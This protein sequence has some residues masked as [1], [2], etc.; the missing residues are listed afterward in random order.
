MSGAPWYAPWRKAKGE[1]TDA[2]KRAFRQG[3]DA[4]GRSHR[5][6]N[7]TSGTGGPNA[8]T[9]TA[10]PL[11]RARS[12][13]LTRNNPWA[14]K[15]VSTL[16]GALVG[17]GISPIFATGDAAENERIAGLWSE[18]AQ[19]CDSSGRQSWDGACR[20][21]ARGFVE[22]GE[23]LVRRR[24][25]RPE[26]GLAVPVQL[27]FLEADFLDDSRDGPLPG[28]GEDVRGARFDAIG[29]PAGF[30]ILPRHPG[31][32]GTFAATQDAKFV[33]ASEIAH[34]YEQLR[35]GQA[36][37][38]PW[39][40]PAMM[41]LR[42]LGDYADAEL[43]RKRTEACVAAFVTGAEDTEDAAIGAMTS[44]VL[45]GS[46]AP[47]DTLEPGL[48][49]H[50]YG[51]KAIAF[52]HPELAGG[53]AEHRKTEL[54]AIAAGYRMTYELLTGDLSAVNFSSLRAG[55]VDF[56]RTIRGVQSD[57]IVNGFC[58]RVAAWWLEA[59]ELAGLIRSAAAV[60]VTWTPPVFESAD[61]Q[62]EANADKTDL[63]T[64][65]AALAD[66]ISRRNG[67]T[68]RDH[69]E[70]VAE[71]QRLVRELGIELPGAVGAARA[72]A[73]QPSNAEVPV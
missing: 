36:R 44:R 60:R 29:R 62:A 33:A 19:Q 68:V 73:P 67:R 65:A 34:V 38:V 70:L 57:V 17:G 72:V 69:L 28:G 46:G 53:F 3:Y 22:S 6:S 16:A 5:T 26:D 30:W 64:G 31:E 40:S 47:L 10:L 32:I 59:A 54:L 42:E 18:W 25:R 11:L 15:A 58:R 23:V 14:A 9:S 12:R 1:A 35:P 50:V 52:N 55:L 61:R 66:V 49:A 41:S 20:L 2:E 24:W 63:E 4:A 39:G 43:V 8:E 71:G 51:G 13:E 37:G 7:W 48:I 21:V 56:G 27:Q 45:D